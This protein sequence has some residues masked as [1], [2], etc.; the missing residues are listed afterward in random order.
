MDINQIAD[1]AEKTSSH[2]TSFQKRQLSLFRE[3]GF[4]VAD[5]EFYKFTNLKKFFGELNLS[6][7]KDHDFDIKTFED[8]PTLFFIDGIPQHKL[9]LEGIKLK[10]L[11]AG[12]LE[13]TESSRLNALTYL[14]HGLTSQGIELSIAK[15]T[16]C[17]HPVRVIFVSTRSSLS[18]PTLLVKAGENSKL[19]VIEEH[20]SLVSEA[21]TISETYFELE[22]GARIEHIQLGEGKEE[23]QHA[24]TFVRAQKDSSFRSFIFHLGGRLNRRNLD[25]KLLSPGAHGESF[26]LYLTSAEEH[27]DISTAIEHVSAD[28]TSEQLAKGILDG[29]S[30]GIFTG[31]IHIHPK[32][33]RV[34]STQLNKNL[35]LS[36]KAQAHSQPQLEIFADDVKCSHG[37]TTGQLSDEEI[38]Y[39][40]SRGIPREKARNLL[41]HGFGMEVVL[42]IKNKEACQ[43]VSDIIHRKLAEKFELGNVL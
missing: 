35:L 19:T 17:E 13:N 38:F 20:I 28:T 14:H 9:D 31:K 22:S 6:P 32:A 40:E 4:S 29:V 3:N 43:H 7:E 18:A 8:M 34:F 21:V 37:S 23:I 26:N 41:A 5:D 39:F 16:F 12:F 2:L 27:S 15:N 11:D 30:K 1:L 33:Q 36:K 24:S 42:K 10:P 25:L